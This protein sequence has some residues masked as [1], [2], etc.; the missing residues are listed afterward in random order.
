LSMYTYSFVARKRDGIRDGG[1]GM[2]VE[3]VKRLNVDYAHDMRREGRPCG[4]CGGSMAG[5]A[6]GE[7]EWIYEGVVRAR[8]RAKRVMMVL[9]ALLTRLGKQWEVHL[10]EGPTVT[11]QDQRKLEEIIEANNATPTIDPTAAAAEKLE[12]ERY[13]SIRLCD[14]FRALTN[15]TRELPRGD[16]AQQSARMLSQVHWP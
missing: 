3:V 15:Y 4:M 6:P 13:Q 10:E 16:D 9:L 14:A 12:H 5:P 11:R 7:D 2:V 8:Q 1:G